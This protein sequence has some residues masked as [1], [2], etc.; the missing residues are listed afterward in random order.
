MQIK[1]D[2]ILKHLIPPEIQN[3]VKVLTSEQIPEWNYW[4]KYDTCEISS[5]IAFQVEYK[6]E[7]LWV[8]LYYGIGY[9]S[10]EV[11]SVVLVTSKHQTMDE[12]LYYA[13]TESESLV[14]KE[15]QGLLYSFYFEDDDLQEGLYYRYT[16]FIQDTA[17]ELDRLQYIIFDEKIDRRNPAKDTIAM[18]EAKLEEA[19]RLLLL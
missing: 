17:Y 5:N 1:N 2:Y 3:D 18:L 9:R 7:T 6:G 12:D 10:D 16:N 19:K 14:A 15:L 11:Q 4:N 8:N 13:T